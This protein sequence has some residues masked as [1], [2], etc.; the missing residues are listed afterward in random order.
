MISNTEPSNHSPPL[1]AEEMRG[2][3]GSFDYR[4]EPRLFYSDFDDGSAL[5]CEAP[6]VNHTTL[7]STMLGM[8]Q[9]PTGY[10]L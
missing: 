1:S 6:D 7:I 3:L 5:R 9:P 4:T 10:A 2:A 8:A